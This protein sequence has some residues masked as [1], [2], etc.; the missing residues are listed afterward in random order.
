MLLAVAFAFATAGCGSAT[1]TPS[2]TNAAQTGSCQLVGGK[3][4]VVVYNR[5][6][7]KP[8]S[9]FGL[10]SA[11]TLA[12]SDRGDPAIT[13]SSNPVLTKIDDYTWTLTVFVVPNTDPMSH[14]ATVIDLA[15]FDPSGLASVY[16]VAGVAVNGVQVRQVLALG[17]A[18]LLR[19]GRVREHL[20]LSY[21]SSRLAVSGI[22][23]HA[24]SASTN[25]AP[26]ARNAAPKPRVVASEP[27]AN[28]AS[29]LA[30]RPVL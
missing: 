24:T 14:A 11:P 30:R 15:L 17:I 7:S 9:G 26:V 21:A 2:R 19:R 16:A 13:T 28:G 6:H 20:R 1:T 5:D 10:V 8:A 23:I 27:T 12:L 4:Q 29:A 18:W 22:Q 3:V 25:A